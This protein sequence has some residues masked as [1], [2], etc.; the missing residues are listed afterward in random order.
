M[1]EGCN[2]RQQSFTES[3]LQATSITRPKGL[4]KIGLILFLFQLDPLISDGQTEAIKAHS[5]IS[6]CLF[7]T[8]NLF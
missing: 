1:G 2:E 6:N 8:S 5:S 7:L 3:S 4:T